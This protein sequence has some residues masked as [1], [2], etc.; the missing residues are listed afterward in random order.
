MFNRL[1]YVNEYAMAF[2]G[3]TML[4]YAN[5]NSPMSDAQFNIGRI[6]ALAVILVLYTV[7]IGVMVHT[8]GHHLCLRMRATA[9][10]KKKCL[11]ILKLFPKDLA[12]VNKHEKWASSKLKESKDV[13]H[14][15]SN[16]PQ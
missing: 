9:I 1:E 3:Y 7:N 6:L 8:T 13:S 12:E 15:S 14:G 4:I 2:F 10:K 11:F 16:E 5:L